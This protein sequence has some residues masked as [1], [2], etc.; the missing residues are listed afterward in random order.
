MEEEGNTAPFI[1]GVWLPDFLD[2]LNQESGRSEGIGVDLQW[3]VL[4]LECH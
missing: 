4:Q 3:A 2:P 1:F